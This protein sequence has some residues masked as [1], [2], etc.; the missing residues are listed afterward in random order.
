MDHDSDSRVNEILYQHH[1]GSPC[2]F[3][4]YVFKIIM[5]VMN[6]VRAQIFNTHTVHFKHTV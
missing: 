4:Q 6:S 1:F 3:G 2:A 5:Q